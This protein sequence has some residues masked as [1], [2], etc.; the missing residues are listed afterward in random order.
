MVSVAPIISQPVPQPV[1]EKRFL[2]R[3]LDWQRYQMLRDTLSRDRNIRFTYMRGTLE[4]TMPLEIHEFSARLI[5]LFIRILV[6]ELGMKVKTMGSTTLDREAL[7]K[8]AEPDDAYYIQNQ[9]LVAGRDVD[10]EQDPPPD[11]VVEVDI[12]HTD[13]NKLQLYAAMGV[14]EFWRYNGE[15]WRIYAFCDGEYG[16]VE[17]SP[18]FPLVPK[19]KLYEFLA[20]ARQDEVDAELALRAWVRSVM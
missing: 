4:V 18:T 16:E 12:T 5:E 14:P 15:V 13:I 20:T 6:V 2:F 8:S 1:G 19:V 7:D 10:L 9:P 17:E 3:E 11:L